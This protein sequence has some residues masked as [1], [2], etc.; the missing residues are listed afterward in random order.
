MLKANDE[1]LNAPARARN[2][3]RYNKERHRTSRS[4]ST[5]RPEQKS[6]SEMRAN[7]SVAKGDFSS[8]VFMEWAK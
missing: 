3:D 5:A 7:S 2:V 8:F 6:K 1:K 4:R